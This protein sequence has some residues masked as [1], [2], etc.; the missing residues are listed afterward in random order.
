MKILFLHPNTPDYAGDGLFHGLR[1]LHGDETVDYPRMDYMY[2]DCP[3]SWWIGKA[4]EGKTLYGLL[5]D[6]AALNEVRASFPQCIPDFDVIVISQP[7]GF[8]DRL[9]ALLKTLRH[10][11]SW[12]KLVWVDGSDTPTLFPFINMRLCLQEN[13]KALLWPLHKWLYFKREFA[14]FKTAAPLGIGQRIR[15]YRLFPLAISIPAF[16]IEQI[17]WENKQK[18]FPR[19]LVDEEIA[20]KTESSF[21]SVATRSF[22]FKT[23]EAY[24]DD[25]RK[26]RFGITTK[27]SGW[28]ALRHYEYASKGTIL[29]FKQLAQKPDTAA[30]FGLN[31]TNCISYHDYPDLMSKISMLGEPELRQLQQKTFE[32]AS[33]HT[34]IAEAERFLSTIS[35]QKLYE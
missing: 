18:D 7:N 29:C 27:R 16:H 9:S 17:E 5:Q 8:G 23:E 11:H 34:T 35:T 31:E 33:Q 28:D 26:S 14:G 6:S 24:F 20:R 22:V 30:P 1:I 4:N 32:W 13:P 15:R 21:G 3:R 25:I 12:Q 10:Y 19:Y 2:A